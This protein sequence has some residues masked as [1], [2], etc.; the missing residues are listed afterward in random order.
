L[1]TLLDA[2]IQISP[3]LEA[4]A[5]QGETDRNLTKRAVATM[6]DAGLYHMLL[7]VELGG[8]ETDP[9]TFIEVAAAIAHAH[10]S[11]GWCLVAGAAEIASAGAFLDDAGIDQI[12]GAN[13]KALIHGAGFPP[14]Q[15]I[16]TSDGYRLSGNWNYG[17]SIAHADYV[18]TGCFVMDGDKPKLQANGV[19]EV[20]IFNV[21]REEFVIEDNWNVMGLRATGSYDYRAEALTVAAHMSHDIEATAQKR[22]G[23]F[24]SVGLIGLTAIGQTAFALGLAQRALDEIAPLA[25]RKA[26]LLGTVGEGAHFQL[27]YARA[28]ASYYAARAYVFD[29]WQGLQLSFDIGEPLS[30][31]QVAHMRACFIHAQEVAVQ[32]AEFAYRAGGGVALR[33]SVL[34]R[35]FRDIHASGQHVLTSSKIMQDCGKVLAGLADEQ[36]A[37]AMVGLVEALPGS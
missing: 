23:N 5:E 14:G 32:V 31:E 13:A 17:S 24:F 30:L 8:A 18:H 37:W 15:A 7:P 16:E 34:Q 12:F 33:N 20:R 26:G 19:P 6:R 9:I 10:G 3:I 36:A 21:A 4:E 29:T 35:C 27:D 28:A 22:G 11:A 1:E 25:A 2:A